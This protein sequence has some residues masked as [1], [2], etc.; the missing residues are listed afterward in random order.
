MSKPNDFDTHSDE[1]FTR[2]IYNRQLVEFDISAS[3]DDINKLTKN[4]GQKS[5]IVVEKV[6]NNKK[7]CG[8][9]KSKLSLVQRECNKCLCGGVYCSK[10]R[11][12]EQH[13]CRYDHKTD[14]KKLLEK[15][16]PR[17]VAEK[18]NKI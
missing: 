11:L 18:L 1:L 9:C 12:S 8:E 2:C 16:N 6:S 7:R 10:H 13:S 17:I 3:T 14:G 15:R 5:D 4:N